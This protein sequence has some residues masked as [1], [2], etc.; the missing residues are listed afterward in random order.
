MRGKPHHIACTSGLL[1]QKWNFKKIPTPIRLWMDSECIICIRFSHKKR[2]G[3]PPPHAKGKQISRITYIGERSFE[4][5]NYMYNFVGGVGGGGGQQAIGKNGLRMHPFFQKFSRGDPPPP[6]QS[7]DKKLP[8]L[9][10]Y[11]PLQLRWKFSRITYRSF[12]GK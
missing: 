2:G 11:D 4:G 5:K 10:L 9:A 3:P 6:R 7:G 12:E 1:W 8:S